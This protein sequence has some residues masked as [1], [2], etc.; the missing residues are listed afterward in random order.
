MFST[1]SAI[2]EALDHIEDEFNK[3]TGEDEKEELI[4]VIMSLRNTMDKCVQHW[5]RFEERLNEM[6]QKYNFKLP[7]TLPEGF[8][9]DLSGWEASMDMDSIPPDSILSAQI[10]SGLEIH[11]L[12]NGT[13]TSSSDHEPLRNPSEKTITKKEENLNKNFCKISEEKA[14]TSFRKA[15]GF[16]DLAMIDDAI[17]EFEEVTKIEPNF[18]IGH[19]CLGLSSTQKGDYEKALKEL[20]L[21][22][23]LD[24]ESSLKGL[25]FNTM[26]SIYASQE[27]YQAALEHFNKASEAEPELIEAYFNQGAALFNLQEFKAAVEKF[28]K[29]LEFKSHDWETLFYI[30]KAYSYLQEWEEARKYMEKAHT[31]NPQEALITFE[32]GVIY[33]LM[34]NFNRA[35]LFFQTTRSLVE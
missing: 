11:E 13:N 29:V 10:N 20:K 31:L 30:G 6:Q 22:T 1:F 34:G 9:D 32:L 26:G 18:I 2:F 21:V 3:C 14:I 5:L 8:L 7:D 27:K 24:C 19:F 15:L 4:P 16:W 25:A 33:R 12:E 17:K 28:Q 23:A 35:S